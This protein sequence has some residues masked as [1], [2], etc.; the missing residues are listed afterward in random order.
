MKKNI[1]VLM[2]GIMVFATNVVFADDVKAMYEDYRAARKEFR[3][4]AE[5]V[6]DAK[7]A[8]V[9]LNHNELISVREI[10]REEIVLED[11]N[12]AK[13]ASL[14]DQITDLLE[15][16]LE[17]DIQ[18]YDELNELRINESSEIL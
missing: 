2:L 13:I 18:Y 5:L 4:K 3:A 10:L 12:S 1:I 9:E 14:L 8:A 16:H 17:I 15:R 11:V 7:K 6:K